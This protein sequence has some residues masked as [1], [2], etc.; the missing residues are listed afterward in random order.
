MTLT[1]FDEFPIHQ[2]PKP[3]SLSGTTDRNAYGRYWFGATHR[4]GEFQIE[5]AFGRYNNLQVQ[6]TSVSISR[7]GSQHAFHASRRAS[8]DPT[9]LTIGPATLE[10]I[11]PFRQLRYSVATNETGIT[12]DMRWRS[13][14]GAL[15]EDH[16]VMTDGPHTILDMARYMQFGTWEGFVDVDGDR[17]EFTHD[18]VVGIRDRSWGVRPVGAPAPGKLLRRSAHAWLWSPIHFE[19][20]CRCRLVPEP[21]RR[22]LAS[23]WSPHRCH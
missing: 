20:E 15:L 19:D 6:D 7:N 18:E 12:C 13:R 23:R 21:R 9:E 17:T 2:V 14:V 1:P 16:T 22:L 5:I 11:E 4:G 10:I 3:I 8:D